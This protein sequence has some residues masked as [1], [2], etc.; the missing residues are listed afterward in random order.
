LGAGA[1]NIVGI[2]VETADRDVTS[3]P[4]KTWAREQR[5]LLGYWWRHSRPRCYKPASKNVGAGAENIVGILVET[6]QTE[7]LQASR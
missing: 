6:Q 3:Q 1:E 5:T 2:L 4:L 7:M